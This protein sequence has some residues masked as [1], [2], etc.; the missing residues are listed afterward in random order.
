MA[1][2]D[3]YLKNELDSMVRADPTVFAFL[4]EATL[5]GI[6]YWD[7]EAPENEWMSPEFWELFGYDPAEKRHL[8]SEW[9]DIIDPEDLEVAKDNLAKHIADSNHPYDQ[10]VRYRHQ[11]GSTVWV[12]CRGI[13]IRD[14]AGNAIRLLGAH[15]DV[16]ALKR[17]EI[18][19]IEK[20]QALQ[21][22]LEA[23][24]TLTAEKMR[25]EEALQRAYAELEQRVA[26]RTVELS[27][28]NAALKEEIVERKQ[29]E[30]ILRQQREE[31]AHVTR[32]GMLG[33]ISASFAHELNQPL[34]AILTNAQVLKRQINAEPTG[35]DDASEA[36]SDV[37]NDAR[38]AGEVIK[39]LRTL[40][41]HGEHEVEVV[42][43]N[44]LVNEVAQLM[45][46]E[47]I[48]KQAALTMELAPDLP[49]VSADRVQL[50]Q[51]LLNFLSNAFDA[52]G[53]G[54]TL[55]IDIS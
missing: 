11:D 38:R 43:I 51:I 24:E 47:I 31:L 42:D 16:T 25:A 35:L 5:D 8:V 37:I 39:R 4:Q 3:N 14:G 28:S 44:Q 26:D 32:I 18:E 15:N 40:L 21:N 48:I 52:M 27:Q 13:A 6:W 50:Q 19:L 33:E 20:Q 55:S 46:S 30:E 23:A 10:I 17:F 53:G 29:V 7:L 22:A 1:K 41:K 9:Q 34:A 45:N 54:S 2:N 49:A 36:I 12:R